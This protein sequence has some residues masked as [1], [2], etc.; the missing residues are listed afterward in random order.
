MYLYPRIPAAFSP[1]GLS[2]AVF[3]SGPGAGSDMPPEGLVVI[4][5]GSLRGHGGQK[6][7]LPPGWWRP[8]HGSRAGAPAAVL[9][10][11]GE[12]MVMA[13]AGVLRTGIRWPGVLKWGAGLRCPCSIL[14]YE[15]PAGSGPCT[16]TPGF[17][18]RSL[19]RACLWQIKN[20]P[21]G[22][23]NWPISG[24]ECGQMP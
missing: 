19:R 1:A 20:T 3:I 14:A 24:Q 12:V 4:R 7:V 9:P 10:P 22:G 17:L 11:A 18:R 8:F 13:P 21:I 23:I 2:M 15:G 6:G 16:Y 5:S